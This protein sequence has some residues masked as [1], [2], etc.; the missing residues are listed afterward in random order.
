MIVDAKQLH[1]WSYEKAKCFGMPHF[2]AH[3]T[4]ADVRK[5]ERDEG[6]VCMVCGKPAT[7]THH[8]PNGRSYFLLMTP[9]GRFSLM[10]AL[11]ALCRDC[12]RARTENRLSIEWEWDSDEIEAK[13]WSGE[14]LSHGFKAHSPHLNELGRWVV[15]WSR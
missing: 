10:P 2:M 7:E 8:E 4:S 9:M 1:G 5:Y 12:H 13:W 14:L 3:Y 15:K 6:A 11:I